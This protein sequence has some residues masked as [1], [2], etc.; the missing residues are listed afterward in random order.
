MSSDRI[1]SAVSYISIFFAPVLL[2]LIV[3][4]V[5]NE[6]V[7]KHAKRAFVSHVLPWLFFL[8]AMVP[9][10]IVGG[11]FQSENISIIFISLISLFMIS[12]LVVVILNIIWMIIVLKHSKTSTTST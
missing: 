6:F 11:N 12:L 8:G 3:W 5:G 4:I 2:P 1:I 7:S 10:W 9:F